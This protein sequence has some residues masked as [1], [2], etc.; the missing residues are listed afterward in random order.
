MHTGPVTE[1]EAPDDEVGPHDPTGTLRIRSRR[2]HA[3]GGAAACF[4]LGSGGLIFF[5]WGISSGLGLLAWAIF[6]LPVALVPLALFLPMGLRFLREATHPEGRL[7]IDE[8]GIED[9]LLGVGK[10]PWSDVTG[11]VP[12]TMYD[13][14]VHLMLRDPVHYLSRLPLPFRIMAWSNRVAG[15][16]PFLLN[17]FAT[18]VDP[19]DVRAAI[20]LRCQPRL[21]GDAAP[22]ALPPG[23]GKDGVPE[24]AGKQEAA[25]TEDWLEG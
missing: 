3:L 22:A 4:A 11:Y 1:P 8:E 12:G 21:E 17:L 19:A 16:P 15:E 5:P 18:E 10:I 6:L 24:S 7:T 9:R 25:T 14:H 20:L 23:K 2:V 13:F